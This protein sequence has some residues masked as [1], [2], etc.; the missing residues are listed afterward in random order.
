[1]FSFKIKVINTLKEARY[2]LILYFQQ[3]KRALRNTCTE[4]K[5]WIY[6]F[7]LSIIRAITMCLLKGKVVFHVWFNAILPER[8]QKRKRD[9]QLLG[10]LKESL[11]MPP[12][13]AGDKILPTRF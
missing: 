9:P 3:L 12:D 5:K 4:G 2:L 6:Y 13:K 8:K 1:M 10:N 11:F 7:G